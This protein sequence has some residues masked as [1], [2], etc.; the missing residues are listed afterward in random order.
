MNTNR[1]SKFVS[2]HKAGS[3]SES[4][5]A[6]A[7]L[8]DLVSEPM[9]DTTFLRSLDSLPETI[10][11]AFLD[12]LR[13]IKDAD[14]QWAAPMLTTSNI[15]PDS[16]KHSARLRQIALFLRLAAGNDSPGESPSKQG[17]EGG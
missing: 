8:H 17:S 11:K 13:S 15:P 12:L 14:Y 5:I 1:I 2:L 6:N 7:L 9:L 10:H 4:E 3:L 16:T